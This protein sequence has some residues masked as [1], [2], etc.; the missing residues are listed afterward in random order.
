MILFV[1]VK[2]YKVWYRHSGQPLIEKIPKLKVSDVK[3]LTL[4]ELDRDACSNSITHMVIWGAIPPTLSSVAPDLK[5]IE[6]RS[7]PDRD[8][9][10]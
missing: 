7:I 6:L 8:E 1:T 9:L 5:H 4:E 2:R 10:E 3:H